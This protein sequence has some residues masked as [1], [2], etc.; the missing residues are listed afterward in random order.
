MTRFTEH[1][2]IPILR[3]QS[4]VEAE[5]ECRLVDESFDHEFGTERAWGTELGVA[6]LADTGDVVELTSA[7]EK[8]AQE[9]A[10]SHYFE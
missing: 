7:E 9:M 6:V 4:E 8:Q 1:I 5:V 10:W 2:T 3:D